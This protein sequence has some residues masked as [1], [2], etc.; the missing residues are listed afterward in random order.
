MRPRSY[1]FLLVAFVSGWLSFCSSGTRHDTQPQQQKQDKDTALLA[2]DSTSNDPLAPF[3]DTLLVDGFDFPFGD[4]DGGGTYTS[5]DGKKFTG[6]YIATHAGENYSLGVHTGEDW[7]GN[8]GGNTDLGQPVYAVARGRVLAS[9]DFGAPW[10]N[11]IL[12]EHHYL[13]NGAPKIVYSLYAHL[14]KRMIEKDAVINRRQQLGTIG[15]GGGAYPA[16]LHLEIRMANMKDYETTY[17]P[18]NH[19]K[20]S[21]WVLEH[22][23]EPS[24]FIRAHR[25]TLVP[26]KAEKI[27]IAFKSKYRMYLYSNGSLQKT[28]IIGLGQEPIG[29]K[30]QQGDNKTPE[31]EYKIIQKSRGP[32]EGAY[33]AYLGVAWM[34]LN[35]PNNFDAAVG[36][37]KKWI[38]Q[39][40]YDAIVN[41]NKASKEPLKTT[42]LGGG[43]GIHG[44]AGNW[45]GNDKQDLTWGC[46]SVQN[47]KL[48]DLYK[49]VDLGTKILI[50]P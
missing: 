9:E 31:G 21:K 22:Y 42:K 27:L 29:H 18:S 35:Y 3:F 26:A 44:W 32:F 2:T 13:E 45:P 24:K 37:Q 10:G 43:I 36:L 14:E 40:Q 1:L 41:A 17:W 48:D 11:V 20:D 33:G 34:R 8:G 15:T 6:W 23:E 4:G 38:T 49:E 5:S 47:T 46:I 39:A 19:N 50:C 25:S 28:Y 16:H 30:Q 7:N 12:V